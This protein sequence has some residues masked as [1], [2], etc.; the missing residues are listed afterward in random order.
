MSG[1]ISSPGTEK[2]AEQDTSITG[3]ICQKLLSPGNMS[4]N[5]RGPECNG[6]CSTQREMYLW[7][8]KTDIYIHK[9][10]V[11]RKPRPLQAHFL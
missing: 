1:R 10:Q 8:F 9:K 3:K 11:R 4:A 7:V 2:Q 6:V 5:A